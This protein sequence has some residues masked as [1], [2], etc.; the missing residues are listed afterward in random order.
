[1]TTEQVQETVRRLQR[2]RTP[3]EFERACPLCGGAGTMPLLDEDL[4]IVDGET[5]FCPECF[6]AGTAYCGPEPEKP[7]DPRGGD[8]DDD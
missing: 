4:E 1:M 7:G 5:D 8:G 6:G 3:S 2:R